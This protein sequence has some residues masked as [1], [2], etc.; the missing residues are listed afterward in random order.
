M[1]RSNA[2]AVALNSDRIICEVR[3]WLLAFSMAIV[4]LVLAPL[5]RVG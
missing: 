5:G 1:Y 2:Q 3:L 4:G